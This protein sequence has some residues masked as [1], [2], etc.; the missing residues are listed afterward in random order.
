VTDQQASPESLQAFND[1]VEAMPRIA[2]VV[3]EFPESV[4]GMAFEVLMSAFLADAPAVSTGMNGLKEKAARKTRR[5]KPSTSELSGN[6]TATK[7]RA[8]AP[9]MLKDLDLA[10]KAKTSFKDFV[11]EKNPK[12]QDDKNAVS[13]YYLAQEAGVS[14]ITTDHVFTCYR[15]AG[16]KIPPSLVMS[17]RLTAS[18]KAY[19]DT[20]N[21]QSIL[22]TNHGINRVEHDLPMKSKE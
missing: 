3:K 5:R 7:R 18:K 11:A 16:W 4:Q 6:G 15:V 17:L 2:A 22:L 9:T 13:V 1:L 10:P 21:S 20:A 14:P 19:I 8:V 12:S